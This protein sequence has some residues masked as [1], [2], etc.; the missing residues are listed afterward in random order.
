MMQ[1]LREYFSNRCIL[2]KEI[3]EALD[4]RQKI[5]HEMEL[6]GLGGSI[7]NKIRVNDNDNFFF[8]FNGERF[9]YKNFQFLNVENQG[10]T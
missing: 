8:F 6:K 4:F 5:W 2:T 1:T 7:G 10:I 9:D 3:R